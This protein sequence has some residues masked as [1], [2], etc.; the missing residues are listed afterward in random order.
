MSRARTVTVQCSNPDCDNEVERLAYNVRRRRPYCSTLCQ[1]ADRPPEEARRIFR[2]G[3]PMVRV[4]QR[5]HLSNDFPRS[6]YAYEHILVAEET[7][8]RRLRP[9]ERVKRLSD[10]RTDVR[11][12]VLFVTWYDPETGRACVANVR[13][14]ATLEQATATPE[15][16]RASGRTR[17]G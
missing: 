16:S 17:R 5:H 12:E 4:P 3:Y 1:A 8:G 7:L 6:G 2:D 9:G 10:D 13:D 11:P 15:S 14:L